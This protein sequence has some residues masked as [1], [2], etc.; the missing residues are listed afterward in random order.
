MVSVKDLENLRE[1]TRDRSFFI[2]KTEEDIDFKFDT[3]TSNQTPQGSP[4]RSECPVSRTE[5]EHIVQDQ[6]SVVEDHN[7]QI[8]NQNVEV[9]RRVSTRIKHPIKR[10]GIND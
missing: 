5:K 3:K 10:L 6:E 4:T 2:K 1:F 7:E 8:I 9:E